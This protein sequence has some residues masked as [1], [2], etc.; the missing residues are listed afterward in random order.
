MKALKKKWKK[1]VSD[2]MN[3]AFQELESALDA[4]CAHFNTLQIL[5]GNYLSNKEKVTRRVI[6]LDQADIVFNSITQGLLD[7]VDSVEKADLKPDFLK[8]NSSLTDG[9]I[10]LH[11]HHKFTCNRI[12]QSDHFHSLVA[13]NRSKKVHFFSI[14]GIELQSHEGIFNRFAYD[15]EGKL[16]DYLNPNMHTECE[17][18]KVPLTFD[19]SNNLTIYKQNIL[20]SLFTAL[21]VAP[22]DN[23]P[24]LEKKIGFLLD[25]SP[26]LSKLGAE[27]F[28]CIFFNISQW[29]WD[30][31]ITP[32]VTRWFITEFCT[33]N[34]PENSPTFQ[35]FFGLVM[36]EDDEE[37]QTEIREA[38]EKSE[39]IMKLPELGMVK[40][41]DLHKWFAKYNFVINNSRER[42]QKVKEL[43][44]GETEKY[45]EDVELDLEKIINEYNKKLLA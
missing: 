13:T 36:D 40:P 45:M 9:K 7:I 14:L 24:L 29:D 33:G 23:G 22:M 37:M 6:P 44:A 15:M 35:F 41:K 25:K 20:K 26:M 30:A 3:V 39:L 42:K 34:L 27:D 28:V 17:S 31:K 12:D 16:L 18:L 5:K 19:S 11:D 2:N 21:K 10:A 4:S 38:I 8:D 1:I 43:F 32:V